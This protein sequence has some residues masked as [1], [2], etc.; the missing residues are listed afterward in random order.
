V[1]PSIGSSVRE[2]PEHRRLAGAV[3]AEDGEDLAGADLDVDP[4]DGA[5]SPKVLTRPRC[6]PRVGPGVAAGAGV[7][8]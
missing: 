2:H 6:G 5:T 8:G 4:V 7:V 1:P 3:R